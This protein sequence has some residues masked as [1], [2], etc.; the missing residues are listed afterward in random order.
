MTQGTRERS[1]WA[2]GWR[3]RFPDAAARSGLVQLTRAM[4]PGA[5]PALRPLP[6]GHDGAPEVPA[7]AVAMPD[8]LAGFATQAPRDRA[9]CTRGRAF[10]DLIAGFAGDYAGAPDLVA[11]PRDAA[12]VARTLEVCSERGW[13]CVPFGG[14]TSVVGGVDAA[15]ARG[16][17]P[18]VV[19]LD[20]AALS[21][22]RE[23]D[24]TSRL[25]R[26]AAGTLGPVL[27]DELAAHGL[28]LRHFPQSF[29]HS[30][31]GGWLATRAGGHYATGATHIDDLT[32]AVTMITPRGELAT[33]RH[34]GSAAGP[35]PVRLVLGSEGALGVITE[36][37]MRV[38]PRPRWRAS[39]SVAFAEFSAGVAAARALAQ[40]GLAPSNARLLD[41]GEARLSRVRA[42]GTSVLL[43]GF[44]SA[45]HPLGPW[46]ARAIELATDHGGS[47]V[48]GPTERDDASRTGAAGAWRQ[49]FLDAPYMQSALLSIG[50]LS[51]TFETACS[52]TQFPELHA[53]VTAAVSRAL[54]EACGGGLVTCRFTHLYP[55]GPAPY[56]TFVG[57]LEPG[58]EL[59]QWRA[60]KAAAAEAV[61]AAGGTITHH[62][63]VGRIHRPWYDR[64]R[65][66]LFGD[67]LA[68][69]KHTLDP[70]GIL[71][72][73]VLVG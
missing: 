34:P 1:I 19:A 60:I 9:M 54:A 14:G 70:Q 58:G 16:G 27:E 18:A 8:A 43:I 23:V 59:A 46:L 52:W 49:A 10:P 73:G 72:P 40:S 68:A 24:P 36:A 7:S 31:L 39:A 12:E 26:I 47:V 4:L 45:D 55:D 69:V 28:T 29:E 64:E 35:E 57:A 3:D 21:G 44:E 61:A 41:G 51:D 25:A 15:M 50:V 33:H 53:G 2:W 63:A 5:K 13:A 48:A 11:R 56:Y 42:D 71:N 38:V 17:R 37:W 62:H 66:A 20:L 67:A 22:V 65:P 30:T 6:P 32:H